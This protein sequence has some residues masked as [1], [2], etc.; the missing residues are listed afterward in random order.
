MRPK[1]VTFL[2]LLACGRAGTWAAA[3]NVCS[4]APEFLSPLGTPVLTST[5]G[6]QLSLNCT[7]RLSSDPQDPHCDSALHW[8]KDDQLLT[9]TSLYPRNDSEWSANNGSQRFVRSLLQVTVRDQGS[10]GVFSCRLSNATATFKLQRTGLPSHTA[11]V[12]A[13]FTLA[14]ALVLALA[15]YSRCRLNLRLWYKNAYGDYEMNDGKLYDAYVS[16]VNN[17]H[18][19]KFV[20]F[21]LKPHLENRYSYKLHLHDGDILPGSEPSAELLMNVSR[22]RRLIVVLSRA[23][24]EQEWCTNSFRE[25]LWRLQELCRRPVFIVFESQRRQLS[26]PALRLLKESGR[27][28]ALLLWGSK[29]MTP[30]S[31]FWKSLVLEMPRKLMYHHNTGDPQTL[32]QDDK[33]PMLTLNPDYLDCRPDPD[34]AGDLGVRLPVYKAP[35]P[36][37][38]VLPADPPPAADPRPSDV[39]IDVS[40]LGSRNYGAR[41]D[42][43][44][45]VTEEDL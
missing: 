5:L 19:R 16:Y 30:S 23:Y 21:I 39:D 24:L 10:Y 9:N 45:L 44:C 34:P 42:F 2:F 20:N 15:L 17:E 11:A 13:A 6:A 14:L 33:D 29:S 32:L 3:D 22:C 4:G 36:R 40:D 31:Q 7:A 26:P 1:L 28:V 25:G 12:I 35:R 38:P 43:Y 18:D 8:L 41:T 37:A 27:S